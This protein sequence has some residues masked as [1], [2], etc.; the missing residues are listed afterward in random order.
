MCWAAVAAL[1]DVAGP[2]AVLPPPQPAN[3][4]AGNATSMSRGMAAGMW[5]RLMA[6]TLDC[7]L[8]STEKLC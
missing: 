6:E 3:R 5:C 1:A 8:N 4:P 7:H 2:V